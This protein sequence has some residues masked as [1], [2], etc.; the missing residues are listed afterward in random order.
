MFANPK[1]RG[2]RL[3]CLAVIAWSGCVFSVEG[4]QPG[5]RAVLKIG[6]QSYRVAKVFEDRFSDL[7]NWLVESTGTVKTE[8]HELVW[9]CADKKAGTIWCKRR[10]EGPTIVEYDVETVSGADNV[11]FIF[12]G[13]KKPE[14]L[15]ETTAER[16][17]AYK[18]YHAFANY[19]ITYLT[20]FEP[21]WRI[22][23]RKDPG[24][25]LLSETYS[26]RP[27]TQGV[28]QHVTYVLQRDGTMSLYADGE[29]LHRHKDADSPYRNGYHGLRTWNSVL[30]YS[31]FKVYAILDQ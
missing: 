23:F 1:V 22:R 11:N 8:D 17:G 18:E 9:D 10:F 4:A 21:R 19:I 28:K 14:G 12:Y 29:L 31:D 16:T 24:F 7:E 15:L 5:P 30:K 25:N 3:V 20:N 13:D 2:S 27:V 6:E 26:D